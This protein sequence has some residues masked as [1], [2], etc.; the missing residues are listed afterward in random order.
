M[1]KAF[2][3]VNIYKLL[4]KILNSDIPNTI[5]KFISNYTRARQ[6]YTLYYNT[7]LKRKTF[8][9]GV[10]QGGV[11]S[12]TLFNIYTSDLPRPPPEVQITNYADDI[13]ITSSHK[14]IQTAQDQVQ[15]YLQDIYN[16]TQDNDL[17]LNPDKSTSTLFTS[18]PAEYN[19]Q[20]QL[21]MNNTLIPTV[22]HPKI[23]GLTL[24]PKLTYSTHTKQLTNNAKKSLNVLKALTSTSWGKD[25]ETLTLTYKTIIRPKLEYGNT[26]FYPI[27]SETQLQRLQII[28]NTAK[29]IITGCTRDTTISH[30]HNE[31]QMLPIKQHFRLHASLLRQKSLLPHHPLHSLT[32]NDPPPRNMKNSIFNSDNFTHNIDTDI[33]DITEETTKEN[34]KTI[35]T[36]IV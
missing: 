8:K 29:R 17:Q 33:E 11:L 5:I 21:R 15:P 28:D 32:Q 2:D 12:P 19:T 27:A 13:T 26:I 35:H 4:R 20:L 7:K 24:D 6:A 14:N 3:T 9:T 23:L 34:I 30:L 36:D 10:P 1:S 25:K 18:D 16:W 22:K 31:T